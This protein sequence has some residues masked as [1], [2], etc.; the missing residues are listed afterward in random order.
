MHFEY[1]DKTKGLIEKLRGFMAK[2]RRSINVFGCKSMGC[3]SLNLM[4]VVPV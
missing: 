4:C 1:S 2:P 3:P